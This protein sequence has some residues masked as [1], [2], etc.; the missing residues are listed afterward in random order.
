MT[1]FHSPHIRQPAEVKLPEPHDVFHHAEYRLPGLLAQA[2]PGATVGSL[3]RHLGSA[4]VGADSAPESWLAL[5]ALG[6]WR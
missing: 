3:V 5:P 6:G 2:V 4:E 1:S